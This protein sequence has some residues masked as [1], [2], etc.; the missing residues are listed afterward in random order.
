MDQQNE[1]ERAGEVLQ[2]ALGYFQKSGDRRGEASALNSLGV[3][4]RS[5][6]DF[7]SAEKLYSASAAIRREIGDPALSASLSNLGILYLDRG[8]PDRAEQMLE[9]VMKL[10]RAKSDDW[11][12]ACTSNNLGFVNLEQGDTVA[13]RRRIGEGTRSFVKLGDLDGVAEGLEAIACVDAA[14]SQP[15]RAARIAGAADSLRRS[16]GIPLG[17]LDREHLERWLDQA[18]DALGAAAFRLHRS[19]GAEM[20]LDQAITYALGPAESA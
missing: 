17:P 15:V 13:A 11:G 2:E 20:T 18:Q 19:E 16:L 4:T 14:E 7:D 8:E 10:D 6:G 5:L 9:E 3:V 12:M 1:L